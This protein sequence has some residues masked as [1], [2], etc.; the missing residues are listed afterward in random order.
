MLNEENLISKPEPEVEAN[1]IDAKPVLYKFTNQAKSDELDDILAMFYMGVYNNTIGIMQAYDLNGE[2]EE[3]ILVGV[4]LDEDGKPDCYPL[5]KVLRAEDVPNFLAPD[6]KG[7]F[8]DPANPSE[9]QEA[10]DNMKSF[11]DAVVE[12]TAH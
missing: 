11:N 5:A 1:A 7:G 2:K 3:L 9:N 8:Y 10:K 12:P 6:G 4:T